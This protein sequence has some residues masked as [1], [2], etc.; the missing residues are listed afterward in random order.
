[1]P[2]GRLFR[3]D[4]RFL[5]YGSIKE[6]KMSVVVAGLFDSEVD[7]TKAMDRLLR[8][9][10][11]DMDTHVI[12]GGST[13]NASE[14]GVVVP[15]IPNTSGGPQQGGVG[16]AASG[17]YLG[18]WLNNMD[19]VE[20]RF[21]QDAVRE[22]STLALARVPEEHADHVRTIFNTFGGRTYKKE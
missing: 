11:H 4:Q 21:Y 15:L 14:P 13:A 12:D 5:E 7:A 1:M 22:G 16:P 3:F 10:I 19:E 9:D 18:N 2:G 8:E 20:K 6:S 17:A